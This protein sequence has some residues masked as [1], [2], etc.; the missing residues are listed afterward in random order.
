MKN[1]RDPNAEMQGIA[2]AMDLTARIGAAVFA[3]VVPGV[4]GQ[5]LDQRW[6]TGFLALLGFL[7]G[8]PMGVYYLL[9]VS[10]A[11]RN[12]KRTSPKP[13]SK[14]DSSPTDDHEHDNPSE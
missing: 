1:P 14:T 13:P 9:E 7:F 11:F 3:M 12:L 6:G 5:W 8:I 4:A 2:S 10:G